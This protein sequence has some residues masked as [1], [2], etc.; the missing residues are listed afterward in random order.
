MAKSIKEFNVNQKRI[1]VRCDFDLP[2]DENGNILDD[3]RIKESLPT[4]K[5]LLENNAKVILMAHEGRPKGQVIESMRLTAVKKSLEGYLGFNIKKTDDCIGKEVKE[6]VSKMKEGEVLLLENLRF[7]KEETD[8][9]PEFAKKLASLADAY[10]NNAFANS[11]RS[12]ASMVAITNYLPSFT[13]LTLEKEIEMLDK[14]SKDFKKPLVAIVG[15]AKIETKAKFI[16]EMS[17][18]ADAVIISGLIEKEMIEKEMKFENQHKVVAPKHHIGDLDID[19]EAI[20]MFRE[21]ILT[22]KT[23]IWNGPFGKF[24]DHVHK[25]GTLEIAKAIVESG[26]FAVVGGDET[27]EFLLREG[28]LSSFSHVSTGGGA[29]LA[30]LAGEKLPGIVAL[31]N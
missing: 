17:K 31:S 15:G 14:I 13:G 26:A 24:E 11:H 8:N 22:A 5:Y 3:F 12:H 10:V 30:Y 25:K 23:I 27:V 16:E 19:Q 1:L 4:I 20:D 2:L 6:E 28:L 7:H 9:D 18:I 21:K 29:M